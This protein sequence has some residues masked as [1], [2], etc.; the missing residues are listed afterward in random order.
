MEWGKPKTRRNGAG[1]G[2][3][4]D[5]IGDQIVFHFYDPL[6]QAKLLLFQAAQHQLIGVY[7]GLKGGNCLI[8]IT[9]LSL[10]YCKPYAQ[11]F[12]EFQFCGGIHRGVITESVIPLH[13]H[14]TAEP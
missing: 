10:Q 8:Q 2:G 4:G 1:R 7:T 3:S 14:Y 5:N 12:I 6:F 11:H 13:C 9:M